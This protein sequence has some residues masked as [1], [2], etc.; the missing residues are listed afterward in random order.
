M[1]ALC[2]RL[3]VAG[4]GD[5]TLHIG[6]RLSYPDEEIVSGKAR[7]L[8]EREF[9]PLSVAL[10]ENPDPDFTVTGGL[11]DEA[12]ERADGADGRPV[13]MTKCEVRAVSVSKLRLTESL[14][15]PFRAQISISARRCIHSSAASARRKNTIR[16]A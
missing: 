15:I 14:S 4:L 11:P 5:V 13:P 10:I 1:A 8:V 16:T 7:E 3:T 2:R 6:Q 9:S 12:F